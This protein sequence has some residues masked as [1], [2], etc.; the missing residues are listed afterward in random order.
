MDFDRIFGELPDM[1]AGQV[2]LAGAGPGDPGLL[3]LLTLKG[4]QQADVIVY[5][6]LVSEEILAMAAEGVRL[7]FAGKRGGM[8]SRKQ[9]DISE[10]LV[11]LAREGK[12]ILRLKG[13][14]PLV[15]GRGG[16]EARHLVENDVSFRIIPGITAGVGGLAYA[17][18]P[19]TDRHTNSAVT[20]LTGHGEDGGLAKDI[21]WE[22]L[23]K[24]SPVVVV[25]MALSRIELIAEKFLSSGRS[26]EEPVAIISKATTKDQ[27]VVVT[28]LG[29]CGRDIERENIKAPAMI[30]IGE[31]VKLRRGLDWL[32][33]LAGRKLSADVSGIRPQGNL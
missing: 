23:A 7:D 14:D 9:Q 8:P 31:V 28:T 32:G 27:K 16:E 33:A 6:A 13:G 17:G 19:L 24:S 18:I 4:M 22:A 29:R 2:W 12:K 11:R 30:V 21:D 10:H 26:P 25:Y 5:D 1:V 20:F 15:F 3:S